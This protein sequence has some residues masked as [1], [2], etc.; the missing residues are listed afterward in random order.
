MQKAQF[1]LMRKLM[2]SINSF[3]TTTFVGVCC[4][5]LGGGGFS[6]NRICRNNE[7]TISP[8]CVGADPL[9]TIAEQQALNGSRKIKRTKQNMIKN[10]NHFF[11]YHKPCKVQNFFPSLD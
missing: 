7:I 9:P 11:K 4:A 5:R 6:V 3:L 8:C 10:F 1:P 2:R